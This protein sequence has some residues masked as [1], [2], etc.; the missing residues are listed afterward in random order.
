LTPVNRPDRLA[1]R[2]GGTGFGKASVVK[3]IK[4]FD[5]VVDFIMV[6]WAA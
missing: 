1:L 4:M 2:P 6:M 5:G 3:F